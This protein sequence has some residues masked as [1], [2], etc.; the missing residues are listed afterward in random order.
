MI[1]KLPFTQSYWVFHRKF[2]AGCYPGDRHP[3]QMDIKLWGLV[4]S[5]ITRVI[6]LMEADEKDH[7]GSPFVD[8]TAALSDLAARSGRCIRCDQFPIPAMSTPT[9]A[10]MKQVLSA[11]NEELA[12]GGTVYLHCWGGKGRTGTVVGCYLVESGITDGRGALDRIESLTSHA[13]IFFRRTP[14]TPEQCNFVLNWIPSEIVSGPSSEDRHRGCLLGLAIGDSVGTNLEHRPSDTCEPLTKM[15]GGGPF[16]F[17]RGEWADN[18]SMAFCLAESLLECEGFDPWDQMERYVQ[19]WMNGHL[20]VT[21]RCFDIGNSVSGALH[22]FL[23]TENPF[24]GSTDPNTAGNGSIARLA[25]VVIFFCSNPAKAIHFAEE[26][27]RTT[28]GAAAAV[29]GCRYLAAL[30]LGALRGTN[31]EELLSQRFCPVAGYWEKQPLH[32]AVDEIAAG[33]F[34]R[35]HPP[36]IRGTGNVVDSLE[37]ALWAFHQSDNFRSGCLLAANLGDDA[38]TTSAVYGQI[39]GA[40]YGA[41]RIPEFWLSHVKW[42]PRIQEIANRLY[43]K[44]VRLEN[45]WESRKNSLGLSVSRKKAA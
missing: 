23:L 17:R 33:S 7:S 32:P 42:R 45:G 19:W 24:S 12:A 41:S 29:D 4:R 1:T 39:A 26:S 28:H 10:V 34:K 16:E 9:P 40:F 18:T 31:K 2:L 38:D 37:A 20:S 35:K 25:P 11:L 13:R 30:I 3:R 14:Q 5:G 15:I 8:Y 6:N 27:S 21:G 22:R 36:E 43:R 44:G